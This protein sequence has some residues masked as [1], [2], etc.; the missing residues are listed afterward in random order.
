[1]TRGITILGTGWVT[2]LGRNLDGVCA[3]IEAAQEPEPATICEGGRSWPVLRVPIADYAEASRLP[4]LR[5][6]G[7]LSLL[8]VT[9]ACDAVAAAGLDP[10]EASR[11]SVFF[12]TT[13]GGVQYTSRFF[14]EIVSRG[15]GAGSPLL[16]PETVYNAAAS[17]VAARFGCDGEA[18][19]LVGDSAVGIVAV[20]AAANAIHSGTTDLAL[21]VAVNECEAVSCAAYEQWGVLR[22]R[23]RRGNIA[24]E[25]AAALVLGRRPAEVGVS[26]CREGIPFRSA[27]EGES[28]LRR[29][30]G[31]APFEQLPSLVSLG[32]QRTPLE[33]PEASACGPLLPGA[34]Q[35]DLRATLGEA[36]AAT[37]LAQ[38]VAAARFLSSG[39]GSSALVASMGISGGVGALHLTSSAQQ[40]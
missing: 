9:A 35:Q 29:L 34:H 8:A 27:A 26:W 13:D 30:L 36:F 2:P 22:G 25:G 31:Q 3:A 20:T 18:V 7:T 12:A 28:S 6:S 5:R 19:A 21:V 24:G 1:M 37:T 23:S 32:C 4:R 14:G 15:P 40:E 33:F 16:F 39:Q 11:M 17:H 38:V 10:S